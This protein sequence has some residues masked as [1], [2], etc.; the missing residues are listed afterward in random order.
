MYQTIELDDDNTGRGKLV[1]RVKVA[2]LNGLATSIMTTRADIME[3]VGVD[4][5]RLRI[6]TT[7]P[8][9]STAIA[10]LLPGPLGQYVNENAPAFPSGEALEKVMPGSSMVVMRTTYCDDSIR[11]SRNDN[12][13]ALPYVWRRCKFAG[14][15]SI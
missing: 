4:G 8:E 11:V 12:Q 6:D 13:Y 10:A 15:E 9:E 5:L 3:P 1:S 2:T 7:K 14:S